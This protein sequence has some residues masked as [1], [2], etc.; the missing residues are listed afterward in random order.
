MTCI[1]LYNLLVMTT[2]TQSPMEK[3][4]QSNIKFWKRKIIRIILRWIL[5]KLNLRKKLLRELSGEFTR[6]TGGNIKLQLR[7]LRWNIRWKVPLRTSLMNALPC[8]LS[9]TP[10]QSCFW[11]AAPNPPINQPSS[12]STAPMTPSGP[13]STTPQ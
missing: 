11:A 8:S 12:W 5:R 10:T 6:D 1:R 13:S 7:H 9:D 2:L 4:R 3:F